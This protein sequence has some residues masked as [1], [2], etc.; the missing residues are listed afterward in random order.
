MLVPLLR[1]TLIVCVLVLASGGVWAQAPSGVCAPAGVACFTDESVDGR[2]CATTTAPDEDRSG[3]RAGTGL[4]GA[5]VAGT[6]GCGSW[7]TPPGDDGRY[8]EERVS[9]QA[10]VPGGAVYASWGSSRSTSSSD[11]WGGVAAGATVAGFGAPGASWAAGS[12]GG[13]CFSNLWGVSLPCEVA[14]PGPPG[15]PWGR[16]LP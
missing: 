15:L 9:A 14:P 4:A 6:R 5:A 16:L 13:E 8:E 10:G 1:R 3:L 2:D 7:W 12:R 11:R